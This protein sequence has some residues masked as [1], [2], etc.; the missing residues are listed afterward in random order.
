[1]NDTEIRAFLDRSFTATVST[2]SPQGTVHSVPVWFDYQDGVFTIW[3]DSARGWVR[4]L[5]KNSNASVV[6]AE[7]QPPFAAVVAHGMGEVAVDAPG[8]DEA[9]RRIVER[10]L[11]AEQI[12]AYLKLWSILRT[13][14]RIRPT[15]VR[16]WSRGY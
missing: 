8:T 3:T 2:V 1:M 15:L 6:V 10:Y 14:V 7:H 4:N 16:S 11:P 5:R 13:I 12:D 9:I